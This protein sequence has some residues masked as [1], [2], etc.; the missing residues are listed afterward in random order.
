[1]TGPVVSP[2]MPKLL[3]DRSRFALEEAV[4]GPSDIHPSNPGV[5]KRFFR[6]PV[7]I[8]A[9]D[10]LI[11][12]RS[13]SLTKLYEVQAWLQ[14]SNQLNAVTVQSPKFTGLLNI[15]TAR[16]MFGGPGMPRRIADKDALPYANRIHPDSPMWMGFA[17]QVANAFGPPPICTFQGNKS[18]RLTDTIAG[19]YF[20]NGSIQVLNHNILDLAAFYLVDDSG[21]FGADLAYLE[22]VQYMYRPNDPPSFGNDDQF[23]DG[24]GPTFLP[25]TYKGTDDARAGCTAGSWLPSGS[26]PQQV[27][28]HK[29]LGHISCLHRSSRA[30]D[31]TPIHIRVDGPGYDELDVPDGSKQPK[32]HFSAFVPTADHFRRMRVNQAATDLVAEFKVEPGDVGLEPRITATRRQNFLAPSRSRRSFPLLELS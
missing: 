21:E 25:N 18:A 22:R 27:S 6:V 29:I 24:G 4:P 1:M 16:V 15:T 26:G 11:T 19:D 32:L 23:T 5:N 12:L 14:G 28:T 31:G 20:Y 9:N 17:D 3:S 13:D 7:R 2:R 30:A 10:M 8:E